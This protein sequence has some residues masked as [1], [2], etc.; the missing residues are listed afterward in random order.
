MCSSD[1]DDQLARFNA[2]LSR[3][4]RSYKVSNGS[5]SVTTSTPT[6]LTAASGAISTVRDLAR[7]DAA[8][9]DAVLLHRDTMATMWSPATATNGTAMPTGLGW[10]VQSYSGERVHWQFGVVRDAYSSLIVKI[11]GK[12]LTLILLANSDG[13]SAPFALQDGDVN[14]SLFAR[15]FLRLFVG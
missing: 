9:D 15:A 12:H 5:V 10:F 11:P 8:L 13:L 3:L 6:G 2:D 4:A 7:F 1:L 14:A